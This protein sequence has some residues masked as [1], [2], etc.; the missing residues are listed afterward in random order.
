[1]AG[2]PSPYP[3]SAAARDLW[4]RQRRRGIPRDDL[5]PW[6]AGGW[7]VETESTLAGVEEPGLTVFLTN[8]ECPWRC[9]M[10]DL[11]R[12]TLEESVP[13]GAIPAQ[14]EEVLARAGHDPSRRWIKLYNAGSFF[15]A[16]AIPTIDHAAI[17][18]LCAPFRRVI[19]ECHPALVGQRVAVFQSLLQPGTQLEVA[20]GLETAHPGV[21]ERLNKQVTREGFS[22]AV[23]YLKEQ[24]CAV[25]AF[26]LVKPPFLD[27]AGALE[28]GCRSVEFA[29]DCGV[30]I[31]SLIPTRAGNGALEALAARGEFSP[32][33]VATFEAVFAYGLQLRRG[34]VFADLWDL[35]KLV[36]DPER[37]AAVRGRL[38]MMN[39]WTHRR[40]EM[41][42]RR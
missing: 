17:A 38:E 11:W 36:A 29:F 7:L 42:D 33:T 32:P 20:L 35:E 30:D 14:L 4:I 10:C 9:L 23:R 28:W 12:H 41:E 34:R 18:R 6:H 16:A 39:R 37:L 24:N 27:E 21:L 15:D 2:T 13:P 25:R 22:K 31:V 40:S 5:S 26:V 19:V 3:K 1:M 8:R